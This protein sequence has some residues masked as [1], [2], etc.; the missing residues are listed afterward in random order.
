MERGEMRRGDKK[1]GGK[2]QCGFLVWRLRLRGTTIFV[3]VSVTGGPG[4]ALRQ[5]VD[6]VILGASGFFVMLR[7]Q[8]CFRLWE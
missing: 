5:L 6:A 3:A 7:E 8:V 1:K 4:V 2:G